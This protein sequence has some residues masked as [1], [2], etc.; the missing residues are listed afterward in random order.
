MNMG[1][2]MLGK[3]DAHRGSTKNH[4]VETNH[5][6]A[7]IRGQHLNNETFV[8]EHLEECDRCKQNYAELRQTSRTLDV[9][10]QMARYQRYP[11]L[12]AVQTLMKVRQS[13]SRRH[14]RTYRMPLRGVSLPA[15]V[16]L[17]I[18]VIAIMVAWAL[19]QFGVMGNLWS[20]PKV[21]K[22]V[23]NGSTAPSGIVGHGLTPTPFPTQ[24]TT[25]GVTVRGTATPS[26][27]T[28]L[29][30]PHILGCSQHKY[31]V[32][33]CGY[34]FTPGDIVTLKVFYLKQ[35]EPGTLSTRVLRSGSFEINISTSFCLNVPFA[36]YA[37]DTMSRSPVYSNTLLDLSAPGCHGSLLKAT[38][39]SGK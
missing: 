36:V 39:T 3:K 18:M 15:V 11:E 7:L 17:I 19:M 6:L 29:S 35:R 5:L 14:A 33:I 28:T 20:Q 16:L 30:G 10:E 32:S 4:P 27:S 23:I 22:Y 8:R 31:V 24:S 37:T 38:P 9:L 12:S 1:R 34:D 21:Q 25:P 26:P 2:S 13:P